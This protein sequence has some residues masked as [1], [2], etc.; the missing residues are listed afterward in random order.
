MCNGGFIHFFL[1]FWGLLGSEAASCFEELGSPE[2]AAVIRKAAAIFWNEVGTGRYADK[3]ANEVEEALA[4]LLRPLDDEFYSLGDKIDTEQL[5][6][7]YLHE[8]AAEL[9]LYF[10]NGSPS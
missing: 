8:N 5:R 2:L 3:Q 9:M 6:R 10:A 7:N 4:L 1:N